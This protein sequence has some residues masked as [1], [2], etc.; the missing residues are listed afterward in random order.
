MKRL[1]KKK[2]KP[3][4]LRSQKHLYQYS[5]A[6]TPRSKA[7]ACVSCDLPFDESEIAPELRIGNFS[8]D[9]PDS[10][11]GKEE[12]S[13]TLNCTNL[14]TVDISID[15]GASRILST[16]PHNTEEE[17][18]EATVEENRDQESI[19]N[20]TVEKGKG[21]ERTEKDL[22]ETV[23]T[24][25]GLRVPEINSPADIYKHFSRRVAFEDELSETGSSSSEEIG[26][27]ENSGDSDDQFSDD[28]PVRSPSKTLRTE[29][30]V[31]GKTDK[32][33]SN[34][35]TPEEAAAELLH[36]YQQTLNNLAQKM[37]IKDI[38]M[39]KFHGRDNED[40]S[41]W[42]QKLELLLTTKGI[43]KTG[44]L[45]TAQIINNLSGPAETFLLELPAEE[46]ENF[47]KLKCA[48]MK[49]YATKDRTWLKRQ[50]LI[51][52]RQGPNEL[53]SDYINDMHELFR[54]LNVAEAEKVAYFTQGLL[55]PMKIEVLK[56]MPE[57]LLDAEECARTLDSINKRVSQ[58]SEHSQVERL[59][60]ALMI[61]GQVPAV[62][63]GANSQPV[64]QQI[65]SINTKLDVLASKLESVTHKK[66]DSE[67]LA[68]YT[69]PANSEQ[70]AMMK[71]IQDL[72]DEMGYLDRRLEAR[73]NNLS[74][75]ILP[76]RYN[77]TLP[78]QRPACYN[79]GATDHF[80][81]SCPQRGYHLTPDQYMAREPKQR[82]PPP[83]YLHNSEYQ[84]RQREIMPPEQW[85]NPS[86]IA[87]S[88][89]YGSIASYND[90][91][92]DEPEVATQ[93]RKKISHPIGR[94]SLK[95][96]QP[97][98]G[99]ES[100]PTEVKPMFQKR[101]VLSRDKEPAN[102]Q[103]REIQPEVGEVSRAENTSPKVESPATHVP[104]QG[105]PQR[106]VPV[107]KNQTQPA[108]FNPEQV[109]VNKSEDQC[110][111]QNKASPPQ[112]YYGL[113][114]ARRTG[115][116]LGPVIQRGEDNYVNAFT[117]CTEN[118]PIKE[119]VNRPNNQRHG[120]PVPPRPAQSSSYLPA[121]EAQPQDSTKVPGTGEEIT[122]TIAQ[123]NESQEQ[124][125]KRKVK[126]SR[127]DQSQPGNVHEKQDSGIQNGLYRTV[128]TSDF[129]GKTSSDLNTGDLKIA[130]DL[131]GQL[132]ELLVD[133]GACVSAIDEQLVRK[134]YGSQPACITDGFIPSVKTINGEIVPVLGKIDVPVKLNG[135]VYQSQF[136]V[137]QNLA[138]EVILGCDFLQEHGAVIDLKNSSLTLNDRTSKLSTTFTQGNDGVMGT[139]VFPSTTKSTPESGTVSR[140]FKK[141]DLKISPGKEKYQ[142]DTHQ[143]SFK[144]SF[145]IFLLVVFYLF[146][147]SRTQSLDE[148]HATKRESTSKIC[149]A[150]QNQAKAQDKALVTSLDHHS[151]WFT[152]TFAH[153]WH[154][155]YI[156]DGCSPYSAHLKD[157]SHRTADKENECDVLLLN[158]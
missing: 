107:A 87:F 52:R 142:N 40:I 8:V 41:R 78:R 13:P 30:S 105:P 45:A 122:V 6:S 136:H 63:T 126:I 143:C 28:H 58:T 127:I 64:D 138:H 141:S 83:G 56:K 9:T 34:Q 47:E 150:T 20:K 59:I 88:D 3:Y 86:P 39:D 50:R 23:F 25:G 85:D 26:S 92:I 51:T 113:G 128:M 14:E 112:S 10:R 68:A 76:T 139:F 155:P 109:L 101:E 90:V 93:N 111:Q 98:P 46:R 149:N 144:W 74:R 124:K 131:E 48:L 54:G 32:N 71:M 18:S 151:R 108:A 27:R 102:A 132:I 72:R 65:Q 95:R 36:S 125:V 97:N 31:P 2:S 100:R 117:A 116:P 22:E 110:P 53:L 120:I 135:I 129:L 157:N 44:P 140:D 12:E 11:R 158:A 130:G 146:T 61:N 84:P 133:T 147:T 37:L 153:N 29:T 38:R 137:M 70:G 5:S 55:P 35:E 119:Y 99:R 75:R 148:S 104:P 89:C 66:V 118:K 123:S 69:G 62:A 60:N 81:R 152:K 145:W 103:Y 114:L 96:E 67:T 79:C 7:D 106:E 1:F 24:T 115:I 21:K 43:E 77:F 156:S 121:V 134:I 42:F 19:Y 73:I 4:Y 15:E 94:T 17:I 33:M 49:R 16:P 154:D 57:T 80:E 82:L 91:K